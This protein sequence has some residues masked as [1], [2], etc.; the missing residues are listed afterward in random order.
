METAAMLPAPRWHLQPIETGGQVFARLAYLVEPRE[1]LSVSEW[2]QRNTRY[3]L[4]ALPWTPEIMDS[5]S[6]PETAEVGLIGPAQASKSTIGLCWIGWCIDQQPD[7][8]FLCQPDRSALDKFVVSRVDPFIGEVT[9]V[10]AKLLP[11]ANANNMHLKQFEG[12]YLFNVWPVPGQFIQVPARYGW[13]DD[14]DQMDDDIGGTAGKAGQGSAIA[15]LEGRLTT[16]KGRDTK[17]VSS[18]PADETGGKT[19][20]FVAGGTMERLHPVCPS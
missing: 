12:M 18:S 16:R 19:E 4:E 6:D 9:S 7:N 5:L 2:A 17:F 10:R 15:L 11:V 13:L 3:D 1:R 14:F 8:F 20:A